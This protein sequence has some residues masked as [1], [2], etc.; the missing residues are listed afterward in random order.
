MG[1]D[2]AVAK[3]Q[4]RQYDSEVLEDRDKERFVALRSKE[5]SPRKRVAPRVDRLAPEAQPFGVSHEGAESLVAQWM[6]WL[7]DDSAT[8]TRFSRDGG[9]DVRSDEFAAQVKNYSGAVGVAEVR[10]LLGAAI[11]DGRKPIFFTSGRYST[12][13]VQLADLVGMPLF[14]YDANKGGLGAANSHAE[15]VESEG[16]AGSAGQT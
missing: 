6:R 3:I 14:V 10:E 2:A 7:G 16:L 5:P 9:V 13:A 11:A 12:A 15:V 8:V 1:L 4:L